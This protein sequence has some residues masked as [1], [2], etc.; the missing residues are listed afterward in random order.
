MYN[1]TDNILM[2]E[3]KA[4]AKSYIIFDIQW[5]NLTVQMDV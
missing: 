2:T 3:P 1:I 4:K 5:E